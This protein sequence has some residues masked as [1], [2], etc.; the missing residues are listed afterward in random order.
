MSEKVQRERD[1]HSFRWAIASK[2]GPQVGDGLTIV[3]DTKKA[4][5]RN[6]T[7]PIHPIK[8]NQGISGQELMKT[9]I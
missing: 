3:F 8:A 2:N 6:K 7:L 9:L 1:I 4:L 5:E